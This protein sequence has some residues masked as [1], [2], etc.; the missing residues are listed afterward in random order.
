[1]SA[2]LEAVGGDQ[3]LSH[4]RISEITAD[5]KAADA[6]RASAAALGRGLAPMVAVLAVSEIVL[7]GEVT[8]LSEI[9]RSTVEAEIRSRVL[10]VNTD[11]IR[12]RYASATADAVIR[13]AAALVLSAELGVVW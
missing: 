9:Y 13:G 5:P 7:W 3:T 4:E 2:L 8:S 10:Q 1:M 12:V 6:I 11:E